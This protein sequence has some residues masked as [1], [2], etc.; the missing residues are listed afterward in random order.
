MLKKLELS[1]SQHQGWD[2][3]LDDRAV[4]EAREKRFLSDCLLELGGKMNEPW[5]FDA[6]TRTFWMEVKEDDATRNEQG[7]LARVVPQAISR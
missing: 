1:G 7:A 3:F 2:R 5:Q 4:A 6:T